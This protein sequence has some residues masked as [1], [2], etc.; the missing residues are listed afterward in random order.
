MPRWESLVWRGP[1]VHVNTR[2]S[3]LVLLERT[4]EQS[5]KHAFRPSILGRVD[6]LLI[7]ALQHSV[8]ATFDGFLA[9]LHNLHGVDACTEELRV[10][11]LR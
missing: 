10:H 2:K 8:V 9:P 11:V 7:H 1:F 3:C 5:T 4:V 6:R